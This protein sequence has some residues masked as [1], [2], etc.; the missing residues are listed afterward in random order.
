[1]HRLTEGYSVVFLFVVIALLL[2]GGGAYVFRQQN[3]ATVPITNEQEQPQVVWMNGPA[4]R[5]DQ[6][7]DVA[8]PS[9]TSTTSMEAGENILDFAK[10]NNLEKVGEGCYYRNAAKVYCLAEDA[11]GQRGMQLADANPKTFTAFPDGRDVSYAKDNSHVYYEGRLLPGADP[12]YFYIFKDDSTG[13]YSKD[14]AHP[15]YYSFEKEPFDLYAKDSS[16][17]YF[18]GRAVE[19]ADPATFEKLRE[20]YARDNAHVYRSGVVFAGADPSTFVVYPPSPGSAFT[21]DQAHVYLNGEIFPR[22][23]AATFEVMFFGY[24][25]DKNNVYWEYAAIDGADPATFF[26]LAGGQSVVYAKDINHVYETNRIVPNL[27]PAT[28]DVTLLPY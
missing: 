17:V 27:N 7:L 5:T 10:E 2:I 13:E 6:A 19:G 15:Y 12:I 28:V 22:A 8:Q 16:R 4:P 9:Y 21:K 14:T 23:D 20:G 26:P 18:E 3:T 24:E 1:M 25:K 11:L